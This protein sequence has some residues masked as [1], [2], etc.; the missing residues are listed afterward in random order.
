MNVM[1]LI[2]RF[3]PFKS[4]QGHFL[5]QF[6]CWHAIQLVFYHPGPIE[7]EEGGILFFRYS[8]TNVY[9]LTSYC[10]RV[11]CEDRSPSR[12]SWNRA[13]EQSPGAII[14]DRKMKIKTQRGYNQLRQMSLIVLRLRKLLKLNFLAQSWMYF[15]RCLSWC[16]L[17]D[18]FYSPM[19]SPG[20]FMSHLTDPSV[21]KMKKY[22]GHF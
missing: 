15:I 22:M 13:F 4:S 7:G 1:D 5:E 2:K 12:P 10:L 9:G 19:T 16:Q 3:F 11:S 8:M 14:H 17:F 20:P 6:F 21:F 18:H